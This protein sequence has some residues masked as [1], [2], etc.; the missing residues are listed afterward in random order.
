M[1]GRYDVYKE[2]KMDDFTFEDFS[3]FTKYTEAKGMIIVRF[4]ICESNIN[5]YLLLYMYVLSIFIPH[6]SLSQFVGHL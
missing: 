5:D 4:V 6:Y 1:D 3:T 2:Y